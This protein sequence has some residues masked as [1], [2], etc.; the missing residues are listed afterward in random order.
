MNF[1]GPVF[2]IWTKYYNYIDQEYLPHWKHSKISFLP[3]LVFTHILVDN[4]RGLVIFTIMVG[5]D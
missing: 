1:G 3:Q 4:T 2:E 5:S